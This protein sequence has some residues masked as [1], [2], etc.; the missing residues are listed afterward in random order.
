MHFLVLQH[1]DIEPPA[2]IADCLLEAGHTFEIVHIY[3]GNPIPN[4]LEDY[5]GLIVM[6]GP[7]S[8][9]NRLPFIANEIALLQQAIA[10]DF[11]ALGICLGAQLLAKAA[12]AEIV[13][14]PKRE[15]GW[16]PLLATPDGKVDTLFSSLPTEGLSVFQWHGETFSLPREAMLLASCPEV[17]HQAFRLGTR[18]Y[19]LQFHVEVDEATIGLWIMAG[20][21]EREF[22]GIK[23]VTGLKLATPEHLGTM[24]AFCRRMIR[25]W[26]ALA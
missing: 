26:L 2:L 22:L 23:G 13:P 5:A 24:R 9:D 19:G 4:T 17:P 11:P 18:Q 16:Y 25:S 8:A 7:M 14:S 15:L 3:K 12:R 20:D 1:L 6:G 21:G 10:Q